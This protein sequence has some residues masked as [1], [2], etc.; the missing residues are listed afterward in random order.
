MLLQLGECLHGKRNEFIVAR[1]VRGIGEVRTA[2][3]MVS[4]AP[5]GV[6][7]QIHHRSRSM[8]PPWPTAISTL[9]SYEWF[10]CLGACGRVSAASHCSRYCA[11]PPRAFRTL[12]W[13]RRSWCRVFR[14]AVP[15]SDHPDPRRDHRRSFRRTTPSPTS[16]SAARS[17][18]CAP[19]TAR[20][21][22]RGS[23]S[24]C[25]GVRPPCR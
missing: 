10:N 24:S 9:R 7:R 22:R 1:L 4:L 16:R 17:R 18:C 13:P 20:R 6:R 19:S 25:A 23:D 15:R 12:A 3:C 21:R 8:F 5:Q 2:H 14:P 11:R